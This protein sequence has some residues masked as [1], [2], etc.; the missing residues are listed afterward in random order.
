[1]TLSLDNQVREQR[2]QEHY[3]E[4]RIQAVFKGLRVHLIRSKRD[5]LVEQIIKEKNKSIVALRAIDIWRKRL[6]DRVEKREL[7]A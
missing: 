2:V 7:Y 5:R 6:R 4:R 3:R 1:M